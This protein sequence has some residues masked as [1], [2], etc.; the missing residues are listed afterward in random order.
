MEI[1]AKILQAH[2][3][4]AIFLTLA[5]G[6]LLG[7]IQI[8]SFKLG[9]ML[10]CLFAGMM[11][12]QLHIEVSP[13]VKLIFFD[14]FLFA[15]GY[16]VGPQFFYG[17]K[18]EALPQ[19]ALTVIICTTC[20]VMAILV[21]K[22]MGYGTG[23]AAGLLAGA[24]SESTV[25][26]TAS[27]AIQKLDLSDAEK[28]KQINAIPVAYAVTYLVGTTAVVW[29]LS[30]IAPK[31]LRIDLRTEASRLSSIISGDEEQLP[32]IGSAYSDWTVRCIRISGRPWIART[33]SAIEESAG[34]HV[35]I[36]QRVRKNG[37]LLD[38]AEE[39]LIS[40][41][42]TIVVATTQKVMLER[43]LP[44]G[45]EVSDPELMDFP[46]SSM[47]MVVTQDLI[48]GKPLRELYKSYAHGVMLVRL[49]RGKQDIPVGPG[50]ILEKGDLLSIRGTAA[51]MSNAARNIGFKELSSIHTDIIFLSM[52]I[53]LGGMI[54]LL[55]LD[56][57]GIMITLSTSGG[58]LVMGLVFGW[59]HS[60]TPAYGRIP[61][62]ALWIFDTL[63]LAVF[64]AII[65]LGAGPT[66][67]SGIQQTG[68]GIIPAGI[69]V[70]LLPHVIGLLA[71]KYLLK[72]NP[73]ILLGAQSGAGTSTTGLK[74][75]Q[76]ACQSRLP[77]LGYT[78]PYALGNIILTAWGPIIVSFMK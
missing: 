60:K 75:V 26:G 47:D 36:V 77:V 24:F 15:T 21:S 53:F 65:G 37:K 29:F 1:I 66:V 42:D 34:D 46:M 72:M 51:A 50:T 25:I 41:G 35:I 19:L 67:I 16:K 44:L 10:G 54:G 69:V 13:V 57:G 71:G 2:V 9:P 73:I 40:E 56:L 39:L 33:I 78:I 11:V 48:T 70:A 8:G 17:L 23:T 14:L 55:A 76:D 31:L 7:K 5:L 4:L 38:P 62:A 18:K 22:L 28:T 61:E 6:F 64:L 59:L 74:A 49:L 52:G 68:W 63:G 27:D 3:E 58:A 20:L 43:V 32:E 45:T 30:S 12:G